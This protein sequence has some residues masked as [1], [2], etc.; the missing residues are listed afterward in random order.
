MYFECYL[1]YYINF[2]NSHLRYGFYLKLVRKLY[3]LTI[4]LSLRTCDPFL[5]K[6]NVDW[7]LP[8]TVW[9]KSWAPT[10]YCSIYISHKM[11][12]TNSLTACSGC[13]YHIL[14]FFSHP[15][16]SYTESMSLVSIIFQVALHW[17]TIYQISNCVWCS[18]LHFILFP[19]VNRVRSLQTIFMRCFAKLSHVR[20]DCV[21][22]L[23]LPS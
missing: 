10:V 7:E 23:N 17:N 6:G 8:F 15:L 13:L 20:H 22:E 4:V 11:G 16:S 18:W 14:E 2:H 21:I 5:R 9:T 12:H 1:C 3:Y 19:H